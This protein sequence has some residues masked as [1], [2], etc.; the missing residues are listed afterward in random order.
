[1]PTAVWAGD[2]FNF[3]GPS[4]VGEFLRIE[5]CIV[6]D[7]FVVATEGRLHDPPGPP[8]PVSFA[9]VNLI[10]FDNCTGTTLL[11]AFGEATLTDEAFQVNRELT[12][13]T[14][15]ATIQVTDFITG[16]TS[17]VD[18]D[19]TWSGAGALLRESERFHFRAPGFILQS[20]LN[21]TFR[22]AQALGSVTLG[23]VNWTPQPSSF[24]QIA[25]VKQGSV[26][27]E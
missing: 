20:R 19:L 26:T 8:T 6:T 2:T 13:A 14:L 5:G 7:V 24:A 22:D 4:A 23:G 9:D 21:A 3:R 16:S 17:N 25:S 12:S 10:Q 27:I 18:V 15:N 11:A 1:M